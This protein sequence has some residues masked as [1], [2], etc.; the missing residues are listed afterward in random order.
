MYE[1]YRSLIQLTV[2]NFMKQHGHNKKERNHVLRNLDACL[3]TIMNE[4]LEDCETSEEIMERFGELRKSKNIQLYAADSKWIMSGK[5]SLFIHNKELAEFIYEMRCKIDCSQL[6]E[7]DFCISICPPSGLVLDGV[8]IGPILLSSHNAYTEAI[9]V[10]RSAS[11]YIHEGVFEGTFDYLYMAMGRICDPRVL[12]LSYDHEKL[13]KANREFRTTIPIYWSSLKDG[14]RIHLDE[15]QDGYSKLEAENAAHLAF[16]YKAYLY[17]MA[18]PDYVH[19]GVPERYV[20]G[21][22]YGSPDPSKSSMVKLASELR[23]D[24]THYRSGHW[25][26]G[27][28]R[29]TS[30]GKVTWV[31]GHKVRP[32]VVNAVLNAETVET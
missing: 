22:K 13:R 28:A 20:Q 32:H 12:Y 30:S 6:P 29:Q 19:A 31:R 9:R 11:R 27:H 23:D 5:K 10:M 17:T 1:I 4:Y 26:R 14:M 7:R 21:G 15:S 25:R 2:K 16:A 18:F 3:A 24:M 8:K